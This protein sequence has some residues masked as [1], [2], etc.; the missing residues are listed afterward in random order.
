MNEEDIRKQ[1]EEKNKEIYFNKLKLDFSNNLEVL[2]LTV[3]NSLNN[4]E[5]NAIKRILNI[6][7]SFQNE[8]II[9]DN[10]HE[11]IEIYKNNLMNLLENKKNNLEKLFKDNYK[12][13]DY[14]NN[15][16][17]SDDMIKEELNN[18]YLEKINDLINKI[19]KLYN[20]N[21]CNLRIEEYLKNILKEDIN[22][23]MMNIIN[24]RDIILLNT[25]NETYL[26]Y[27]ELNKNTIGIKN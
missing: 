8:K 10:I 6:T 24:S 19:T 3:D 7:E 20:D 14:K 22:D 4:I 25:F 27:L 1:L 5:T 9:K 15:L 13:E 2:V 12:I 11:F 26:K 21:F 16:E 18:H 17:E 23:K